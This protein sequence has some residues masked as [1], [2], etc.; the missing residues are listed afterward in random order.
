MGVFPLVVVPTFAVPVA[1]M[2]HVAGLT[3]LMRARR[4]DPGLV[5]RHAS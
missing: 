2:L 3:R 1:V 4:A 5:P